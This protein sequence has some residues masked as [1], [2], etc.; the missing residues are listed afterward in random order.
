MWRCVS[1]RWKLSLP[2]ML[3][4][5][6]F[7]LLPL[8]LA[9]ILLPSTDL[10]RAQSP[11]GTLSVDEYREE[12]MA[13]ITQLEAASGANVEPLIEQLQQ[14]FAT[15]QTVELPSGEQVEINSLLEDLPANTGETLS[16]TDGTPQDLALARLRGA[17]A[18]LDASSHDDTTARLALLAEILARPEFNAPASL[19]DRFWQWLENLFRNLLPESEP[20]NGAT[21]LALLIRLLPWLVTILIVATVIWL[22]SYWLQRLLRSFVADDRVNSLPGDEDLPRTAAEARQQARVAAQ[23]GLYRD[24]VRRL[25]LAALLQLAEHDLI[26][27]EHSLTNREV[28]LRVPNDSPI[29]PHLEPV[30]ATF[31]QVWYGM[32]EPDRATFAAYEQEIDTLAV[33]AQRAAA[34]PT[35][36][37]EA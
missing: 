27:Y 33:V 35:R 19:W 18:Q 6:S 10:S 20:N 5:F 17:V 3:R 15:I 34:D 28:L 31:D 16:T 23:S 13:A 1:R 32:H 22:L 24:A 4:R 11:A 2:P 14:H 26:T 29:K 30:V 21:W 37:G 36:Q 8:G 12:L 7:W 25:Y 9:L